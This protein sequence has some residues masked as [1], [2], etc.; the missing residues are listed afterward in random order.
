MGAFDLNC[1]SIER[2]DPINT[3]R[4]F[5]IF[6]CQLIGNQTW[7][8][9]NA[10]TRR[11]QFSDHRYVSFYVSSEENRTR[12]ILLLAL[13]RLQNHRKALLRRLS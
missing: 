3:I 8:V 12:G 9:F 13:S 4:S 5:W 1:E 2:I 7:P 6:L 11:V 10:I